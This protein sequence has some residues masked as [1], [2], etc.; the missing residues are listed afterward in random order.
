MQRPLL[1][2]LLACSTTACGGSSA[3]TA[4]ASWL[5][6]QTTAGEQRCIDHGDEHKLFVVEWD[7]TDGSTFQAR[8][9]RDIVF[10]AFE[11]CQMRVI[12][13]CSD[14]SLAGRY[15][16]YRKPVFTSGAT[17]SF[18]IETQDELATKLPLGVVTLGGELS[19]RRALELT[20]HVSGTAVAT[21]DEVHRADL[22][23]NPRCAE[24]THV[25]VAYNLGAFEL[26]TKD[27]LTASAGASTSFGEAE[28]RHAESQEK[29]RRAGELGDC[30]KIDNHGCRIP[31]RLT[32]RP[33][34]PG[35]MGAPPIASAGAP[36]PAGAVEAPLAAAKAM[37]NMVGYEQSAQ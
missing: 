6:D 37:M 20:Y 32:L 18:V 2:L 29:L 11:D 25:V 22:A 19:N 12:D 3:P 34:R 17:E 13:G 27:G 8:A 28:G 5:I 33:I 9:E 30:K 23:D 35:A 24:A 36:T 4:P 26:G 7:A 21:R 1:A 16:T 10:V 14:G 31:I 15:G